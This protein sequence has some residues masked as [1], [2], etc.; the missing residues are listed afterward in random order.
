MNWNI[1]FYDDDVMESIH[2]WPPNIRLK[3]FQITELIEDEII[4]RYFYEKGAIEWTIKKDEQIMKALEILNNKEKYS[5]ILKGKTGSI[6]VTR[7]ND[8]DYGRSSDHSGI[9][10]RLEL[11]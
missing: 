9:R 8:Q 4:S 3:F 1:D 7:K 11:V 6:L 10:I 5:S 2:A